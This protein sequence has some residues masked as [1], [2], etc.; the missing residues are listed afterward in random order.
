[1][2]WRLNRIQY[3]VFNLGPGK[4]IGIWTQGCSLHCPGCISKS[5][6]DA[7]GGRYVNVAQLASWIIATACKFDGITITGGEPFDQY[8][9]L[10]AF[11]AFLKHKTTL[12]IYCFSGYQLDELQERHPDLLFS[13]YLDYLMDGRY[14]RNRHD[15]GNARGS[16]N[17]RLYRFLHGQPVLQKELFAGDRW[18]LAVSN[19]NDIYMSG[20]PRQGE[21]EDIEKK[22]KMIGINLEFE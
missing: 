18:S 12:D 17:Q 14:L 10:I 19:E 6:W 20:I 21:L 15:N 5:L 4:R 22:F 8:E 2:Y 13:Q 3:P 1:M 9:A 7:K 16:S 11:C